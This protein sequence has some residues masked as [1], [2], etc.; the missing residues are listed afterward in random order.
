[1]RISILVA[2]AMILALL[3]GC[4]SNPIDMD[5]PQLASLS[6]RVMLYS[7]TGSTIAVDTGVTVSVNGTNTTAQTNDSG[8]WIIPVITV[9]NYTLTF[10]KPG[11]GTVESFSVPV[12]ANNTTTVPTVVMS[13]APTLA[14]GFNDYEIIAPHTLSFTCTMPKGENL[15][16][17]F[18]LS[19]D[20]ASLVTNPYQAQWTFLTT[21][22]GD[23]YGGNFMVSSDSIF[24]VDTIAHGTIIY[25]T[26]CVV[27]EGT[28][29]GSFSSYYDPV[30]K[31][32]IYSALG[33]HSGII[34]KTIP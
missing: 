16:V 15:S 12:T 17:V 22:E 18:C 31:K 33:S 9:G 25:A 30:A 32:E 14:V 11:F 4:K 2:S 24:N 20:S 6:G 8:E 23:N 27:G 3:A 5:T 21:G 10:T 28:N 19:T 7:G 1:M 26:V 34:A 13:E 29:Y